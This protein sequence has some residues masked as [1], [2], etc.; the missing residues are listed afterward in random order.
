MNNLR[1]VLEEQGV[2]ESK[3]DEIVIATSSDKNEESKDVIQV[4]DLDSVIDAETDMLKKAG[5][6][7]RKISRKLDRAEY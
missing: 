4:E 2:P 1:E 7:A 3:I 6:V 5:L